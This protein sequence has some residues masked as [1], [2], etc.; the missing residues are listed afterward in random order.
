[1]NNH[2]DISH[3]IYSFDPSRFLSTIRSFAESPHM[4]RN[5]EITVACAQASAI[6]AY[7]G[8]VSSGKISVEVLGTQIA[9]VGKQGFGKSISTP[10]GHID[11]V[12]KSGVKRV[13]Y[14]SSYGNRKC[15]SEGNQPR[16]MKTRSISNLIAGSE[17]AREDMDGDET[18]FELAGSKA[19]LFEETFCMN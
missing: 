2:I 1:M 18:R 13:R 12:S 16:R 3:A 6:Q 7:K 5:L 10:E 11:R 14:S 17:Y 4:E 9:S 8:L 15:S 19:K